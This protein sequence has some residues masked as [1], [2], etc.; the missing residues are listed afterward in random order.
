MILCVCCLLLFFFF[1][2]KT[3]YEMLSSDWSSDVCSSD[4]ASAGVDQFGQGLFHG[5]QFGNLGP[6]FFDMPQG[7]AAHFGAGAVLVAVKRQK[8]AAL[9]YR[10]AKPPRPGDE[11]QVVDVPVSIIA[12]AIVAAKWGDEADKIGRAHV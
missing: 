2:Q 9:F 7:R 12:K 3:A 1:K 10:K 11:T 5:L 6:D 4:L 8:V